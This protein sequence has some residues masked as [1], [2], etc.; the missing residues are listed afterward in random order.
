MKKYKSK[1]NFELT[2]SNLKILK[3]TN[4]PISIIE[5]I[6]TKDSGLQLNELYIG[7]DFAFH[8][9]KEYD[10]MLALDWGIKN[11]T[12]EGGYLYENFL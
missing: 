5:M 6:F 11:L 10:K 2:F 12:L 4:P 3:L 8:Y 7:Q 9:S 1:I